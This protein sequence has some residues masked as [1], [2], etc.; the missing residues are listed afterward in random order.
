MNF[1]EAMHMENSANTESTVGFVLKISILYI[2][3]GL[4]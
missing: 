4:I 3:C 1:A 2:C